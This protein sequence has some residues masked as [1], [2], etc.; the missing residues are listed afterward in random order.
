MHD[1]DNANEASTN[2]QKIYLHLRKVSNITVTSEMVQIP[3]DVK[4]F[5]DF[6]LNF[7]IVRVMNNR[8]NEVRRVPCFKY[9]LFQPCR[10]ILDT[11]NAHRQQEILKTIRAAQFSQ[12]EY[13]YVL[14][15][16]VRTFFRHYFN[17]DILT[18]YV[19]TLGFPPFRRR[20]VPECQHKHNG[21][22]ISESRKHRVRASPSVCQ[23][24]WL[25]K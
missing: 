19:F 6:L 17:V 21:F 9:F 23:P 3:D 8:S 16:Y 11:S 14:A 10:V 7:D 15:N 12:A 5:S 13:H 1:S 20:K 22:P 4:D 24:T 18:I 25:I 2:L